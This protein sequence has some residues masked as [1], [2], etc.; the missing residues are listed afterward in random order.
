MT[1]IFMPYWG[2]DI[3]MATGMLR[4]IGLMSGTSLD[5]VDAAFVETDG[6]RVGRRG[7]SL[8]LPYDSALREAIY[9]LFARAPDLPHDDPALCEV[10]RALTDI[11]AEAVRRILAVEGGA[12]LVGFHGQTICHAPRRGVSWQIGDAIRLSG[13]VGLPVIHDFRSADVRAGGEGAP[14]APWYH[15]ACLDGR[16]GPVAILNIGG[17]ANITFVGRDGS[18]LAGDTGPGN[19]LLDDW[20]LRHTGVACDRDGALARAGRVDSARLHDLLAHDFFR[21]PLPKSLDRQDFIAS[22]ETLSPLSPEDGAATLVAMTVH[23]IARTQLPEPPTAW[24]V[25][26]GGRHNPSIMAALASRLPGRVS[27]V[28]ALGWNGDMLEAECFAFLAARALRGLPLSSPGITGAPRLA[29]G[30]RLS[31]AGIAL[32]ESFLSSGTIAGIAR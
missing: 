5:G 13:A 8:S 19:A 22:L 25:C 15:A 7:A 16:Q 6:R 17:V 18:V 3:A 32:P 2:A 1:A 21:R 26:G 9:G 28:E 12:D 14:L 11:H 4:V 31:S 10:E 24:F 23:A 29:S 27:P 20:A 30:G